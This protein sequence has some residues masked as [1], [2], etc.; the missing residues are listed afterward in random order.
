ML[1]NAPLEHFTKESSSHFMAANMIKGTAIK[2]RLKAPSSPT[3][4]REWDWN[5]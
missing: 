1:T 5:F 2:H 3:T 4:L